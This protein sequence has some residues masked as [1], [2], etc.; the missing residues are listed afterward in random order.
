MKLLATMGCAYLPTEDVM[1]TT[2]VGTT[3]MRPWGA[4]CTMILPIK[5]CLIRVKQRE[6]LPEIYEI[7]ERHFHRL[8][9][10]SS[11]MA[12]TILALTLGAKPP[13]RSAYQSQHMKY[14]T[15]WID[16]TPVGVRSVNHS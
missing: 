8:G 3:V 9:M 15:I 12:S 2:T 7:N 14:L 10:K 13:A 11:Y 4:V 1:E 16:S 6:Y 5:I